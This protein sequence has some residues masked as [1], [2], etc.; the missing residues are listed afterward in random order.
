V[1]GITWSSGFALTLDSFHSIVIDEPITDAGTG[2]LTLTTNHGGSGGI[3]FYGPDG[4]IS[5]PNVSDVLTINGQV[6]TLVDSI[7]S[8]AG[9]IAANPSGKYAIAAAIKSDKYTRSPIATTLEG[10]VNGLGNTVSEIVINDTAKLDTAGFFTEVGSS[11]VVQDLRVGIAINI[12][13]PAF[14][15]GLAGV[16]QGQLINDSVQS[17]LNTKFATSATL[18]GLVGANSGAITRCNSDT[19]INAVSQ[20]ALGGLVGG[21]ITGV[22][23]ESFATGTLAG[24]TNSV[25]GGLVGTTSMTSIAN[26]YAS[27]S[28]G[29]PNGDEGGLVGVNGDTQGNNGLIATSYAAG[30]VQTPKRRKASA[31]GFVGID[32]SAPG[33]IADSYWDTDT[34]GITDPSQGAFSPPNDPGIT[35]ENSVQL[36]AGLP[37]GFDPTV[38]AEDAPINNGLPYLIA[39]PPPQ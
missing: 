18:G 13:E 9:D 33:S 24:H 6:Y 20:S 37:A 11:G 25:V 39:N 19:K 32:N 8:L 2:A 22:I 35:G 12:T 4:S 26:S 14:A 7:A 1:A 31:G 30:N 17:A 23:D 34:S 36:A 15:G 21:D 16:N 29:S 27:A 5:I 3:F 28:T 10:T 38:W